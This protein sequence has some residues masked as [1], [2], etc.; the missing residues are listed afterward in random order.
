MLG[1]STKKCANG[2]SLCITLMGSGDGWTKGYYQNNYSTYVIEDYSVWVTPSFFGYKT[3]EDA[4]NLDLSFTYLAGFG[5]TKKYPF[6]KI[7]DHVSQGDGRGPFDTKLW[8]IG[9]WA[10]EI[11][12]IPLTKEYNGTY[13]FKDNNNPNVKSITLIINLSK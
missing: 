12:P 6:A 3:R 13:I 10:T 11:A 2:A 9:F 1:D 4:Y 7:L 8:G 5:G